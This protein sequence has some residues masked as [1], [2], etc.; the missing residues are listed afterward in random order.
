MKPVLAQIALTEQIQ[1]EPQYFWV[2]EKLEVMAFKDEGELFV[3]ASICPHMGAQM[4][5]DAKTKHLHC[6][7]HALKANISDGCTTHHK[8]TKLRRYAARATDKE[9]T[10]YS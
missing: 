3:Y 9:L 5:Y 1:K 2:R 6:P 7:W 10:I 4:K 8:F